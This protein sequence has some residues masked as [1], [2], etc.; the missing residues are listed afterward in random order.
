MAAVGLVL[1]LLAAVVLRRWPVLLVPALLIPLAYY[2]LDA[3]W[4]GNGAPMRVDWWQWAAVLTVPVVA[5]TAALI[6]IAKLATR[7]DNGPT[8]VNV[9]ASITALGAIVIIVFTTSG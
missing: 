9:S 1:Y 8:V 3:A 7:F 6:C 2:G 5:F 4:W